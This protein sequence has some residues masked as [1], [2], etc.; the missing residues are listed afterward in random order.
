MKRYYTTTKSGEEVEVSPEDAKQLVALGKKKPEDFNI[1]EEPDAPIDEGK[2]VEGGIVFLNPTTPEKA[3][4]YVRNQGKQLLSND[5]EN[6]IN[7]NSSENK[8]DQELTDPTNPKFRRVLD[9]G[10]QALREGLSYPAGIIT[11]SLEKG[12]QKL[13]IIGESTKEEQKKPLSDYISENIQSGKENEGL[14]GVLA[15]PMTLTALVPGL[16]EV[17]MS[18]KLVKSGLRGTGALSKLSEYPSISEAII[19][20]GAGAVEG[21]GYGGL[22]GGEKG[23]E[24][25]SAIGGGLGLGS[26]LMKGLGKSWFPGLSDQNNRNITQLTRDNVKDNLDMFLSQGILPQTKN[27]MLDIVDKNKN[28]IGQKYSEGI[29]AL[30]QTELGN[31]DEVLEAAKKNFS[32]HPELRSV[33][34]NEFVWSLATDPKIASELGI[35]F[36]RTIDQIKPKLIDKFEQRIAGRDALNKQAQRVM[37]SDI[38]SAILSKAKRTPGNITYTGKELSELRNNKTNP[39]TYKDPISLVALAKKDAGRTWRDIINGELESDPRYTQFVTPELKKE[40]GTYSNIEDLIDSPGRTGLADRLPFGLAVGPWLKSSAGYK[41]G[42]VLGL[43]G[44]LRLGERLG[45]K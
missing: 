2:I 30:D 32:E 37:E 16:G 22:S 38:E 7:Y 12:V 14:T 41:A 35:P 43:A 40:Y 1:S 25:G 39:L 13:P 15:D 26:G 3:E 23:A 10:Y 45:E 11:G 34:P 31:I 28:R 44:R 24:Y 4:E 9:E 19:R 27:G 33:D 21:A 6:I 8:P 42:Q 5:L 20:G 17:A 18:S 29:K 36:L